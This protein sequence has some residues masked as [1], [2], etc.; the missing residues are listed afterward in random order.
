MQKKTEYRIKGFV[1]EVMSTF[2]IRNILDSSPNNYWETSSGYAIL[3]IEF[4]PMLNFEIKI[5]I[6]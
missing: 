2:G 4:P 5:C 1:E 6:D 3:E